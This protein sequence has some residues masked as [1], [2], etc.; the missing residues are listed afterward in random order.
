MFSFF[1]KKGWK[2]QTSVKSGPFHWERRGGVTWQLSSWYKNLPKPTKQPSSCSWLTDVGHQGGS[3]ESVHQGEDVASAVKVGILLFIARESYKVARDGVSVSNE[4]QTPEKL[5]DRAGG[6]TQNLP[7]RLA[8]LTESK[9]AIFREWSGRT[10][11]ARE[12]FVGLGCFYKT[13]PH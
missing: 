5:V 4:A 6:V 11:L 1:N 13:Y 3:S 7:T 10:R 8:L 9:E 2:F 12:C